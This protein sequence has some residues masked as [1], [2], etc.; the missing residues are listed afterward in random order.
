MLVNHQY[1][2]RV[3]AIESLELNGKQAEQESLGIYFYK[4]HG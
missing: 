4:M 3:K 2:S 1:F